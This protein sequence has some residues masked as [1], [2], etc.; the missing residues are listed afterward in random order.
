[1]RLVGTRSA[2]RDRR[3]LRAGLCSMPY[4]CSKLPITLDWDELLSWADN[5]VVVACSTSCSICTGTRFT[6]LSAPSGPA[7]PGAIIGPLVL[8]LLHTMLDEYLVRGNPFSRFVGI[9]MC[10]SLSDIVFRP[11]SGS[12]TARATKS[13]DV[14]TRC[15]AKV[16]AMHTDQARRQLALHEPVGA[17]SSRPDICRLL[18]ATGRLPRT[19][20]S[21]KL[22]QTKAVSL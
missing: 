3:K 15:I 20:E 7:W 1:M 19:G 18:S 11:R 16:G 2:S 22:R 9:G 12:V 8:R 10:Q 17:A 14:P 6:M 21:N 5:P 13:A 4:I